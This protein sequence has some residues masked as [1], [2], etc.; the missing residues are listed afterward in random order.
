MNHF[1]SSFI[2]SDLC[3]AQMLLI[4]HKI[5]KG[6]DYNQPTDMKGKLLVIS[7]IYDKIWHKDLIFESKNF[8]VSYLVANNDLL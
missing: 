4:M 5:Y 7:K 8:G 1:Q 3:V 2:S 6:F